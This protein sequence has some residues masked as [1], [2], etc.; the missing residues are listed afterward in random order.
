MNWKPIFGIVIVFS[1]LLQ[2]KNC[3]YGAEHQDVAPQYQGA[4]LAAVNGQNLLKEKK[5]A[6]AL[7][8]YE[9]ARAELEHEN[10]RG[11]L[12]TDEYINYGFVL[13]DIGVIHLAWALY[14]REPDPTQTSV[15]LEK[16]DQE[17]LQ[18]ARG[19][20]QE[21]VAFYLRWYTNNPTAY[22]RFAK[23]IS[24]SYANLGTALKY[25]GDEPAAVGAFADSL[26][27]NPK[28]DRAEHGLTLIQRDPA[29]YIRQGEDQWQEHK[30]KGLL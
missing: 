2:L 18:Q 9:M 6:E 3:R 11:D 19:A 30:R 7:R 8:Y 10:V 5:T 16:I 21:A 23:A 27:Y 25:S 28:N 15:D 4:H 29:P 17:E 12:G 14:G 22:E 13:N 20:L 24:E 1:L 26:R